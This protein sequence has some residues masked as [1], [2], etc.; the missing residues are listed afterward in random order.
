MGPPFSRLLIIVASEFR[1]KFSLP[2]LPRLP[3]LLSFVV[4][5]FMASSSRSVGH[6]VDIDIEAQNSATQPPG[7]SGILPHQQFSQC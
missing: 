5:I 7:T 3:A 4:L 2:P 1:V 6:F